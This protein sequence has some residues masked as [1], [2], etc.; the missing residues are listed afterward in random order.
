MEIYEVKQLLVVADFIAK[1]TFSQPKK[2][3]K[4]YTHP[5]KNPGGAE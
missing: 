1:K 3:Q 5:N 4:N 2:K